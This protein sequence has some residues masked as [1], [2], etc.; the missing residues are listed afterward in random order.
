MVDSR[1]VTFPVTCVLA[2]V[3]GDVSGWVLLTIIVGSFPI[4]FK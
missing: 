2:A 3:Y 4:Y 1:W